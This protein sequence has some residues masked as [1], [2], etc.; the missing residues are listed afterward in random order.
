MDPLIL[1]C[2]GFVLLGLVGIVL[3]RRG[4]G[5]AAPLPTP[6]AP[7]KASQPQPLAPKPLL[8]V[9]ALGPDALRLRPMTIYYGSQTGTAEGFAKQISNE[10]KA[11][12]Y[13]ATV[14]D[15]E[16]FDPSSFLLTAIPDNAS[17]H[18]H[19]AV[20]VMATYGEGDPADNA[21]AFNKW[22]KDA[23]HSG[24]MLS[25]LKYTTFGLGNKQYEHYNAQGRFIFKRLGELGAEACAVYGE[26]DD[27]GSME[28][29]FDSWK[30]ALWQA[31][32]KSAAAPGSATAAAGGAGASVD[33]P[34]PAPELPPMPWRV[35]WLAKLE[36]EHAHPAVRYERARTLLANK[37]IETDLVSKAYFTAKEVKVV[38]TRELRQAP[39]LGNST[40]HIEL[41]MAG[42]MLHYG[43]ADDLAVLCCN[44]PAQVNMLAHWLGLDK[45]LDRWF[46]LEEMEDVQDTPKSLFPTP[47][48]VREA[49]SCYV[50]FNHYPRK[51][52]LSYLSVLATNSTEKARLVELSGREGKA[53]YGRW[54]VDQYRS[55]WEIFQEFPSVRPTL[56]QLLQL[57]P[58]L[59]PRWY[60]IASSSVMHPNTVHLAVSVL[61]M[62]NKPGPVPGRPFTGTCS[63]YLAGLSVGD[64]LRCDLRPS[65]FKLPRTPSTPILMVGPGTGVAPMIAFL[66]ERVI[67]REQG[68]DL[69]PALLFFGCRRADE[70]FIYQ[71][72]LEAWAADGIMTSLITA[73]SRQQQ[74]KVYVQHRLTEHGAEVWRL[75]HDQEGYL[76]VCGA[77][78]MGEDV[79]KAVHDIAVSVGGLSSDAATQWIKSIHERYIVELW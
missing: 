72:E 73:F 77:T 22:I 23:S 19:T 60:T 47:C 37:D 51:Q 48:T 50:D 10:C 79:K 70:D 46:T 32:T 41:D 66:Q 59:A 24:S 42:S 63:T 20:F 8:Q 12:G 14:V 16:S 68:G 52:L 11:R 34:A 49:L 18:A 71:A 21:V 2:L 74:H 61:A 3:S 54:V 44:P 78:H 56:A 43:T 9:P 39:S 27:D 29:D 30:E 33:T 26:G 58:P 31:L 13:R 40:V 25:G 55:I 15:L 1:L 75:L 53:E 62:A 36:P 5:Q 35:H 67:Q 65:H 64:T 69:G 45:D 76:Y 4:Q 28:E 57:L 6:A 38:A 7:A 17:G